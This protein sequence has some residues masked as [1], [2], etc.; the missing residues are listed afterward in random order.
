MVARFTAGGPLPSVQPSCPLPRTEV[1]HSP[2]PPR[3]GR[4]RRRRTGCPR[5]SGL[6][7]PI[8]VHGEPRSDSR[9]EAIGVGTSAVP[10]IADEALI[11]GGDAFLSA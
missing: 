2:C 11:R 7:L 9:F 5:R 4:S 10:G 1:R 3:R 6:R 8:R